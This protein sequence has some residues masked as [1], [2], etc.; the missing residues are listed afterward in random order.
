MMALGDGADIKAWYH[1]LTEECDLKI[2]QDWHWSWDHGSNC[3]AVEFADEKQETRVL[4][5]V[6]NDS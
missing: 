1:F 6:R 2:G 5:K 4:L 3:W